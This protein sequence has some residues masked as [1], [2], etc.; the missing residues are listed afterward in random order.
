MKST[1]NLVGMVLW[2][3]VL[4]TLIWMTHDMRVRRLHLIVKEGR[5]FSWRNLT[6]STIELVVWLAFFGGMSYTTFF[7]NVNQLGNRI[8]Q[9]TRYDPL[10]LNTG[11]S[12]GSSYYVE[13]ENGEGQKPIQQYTYLTE[14]ERYKVDS[15]AATVSSGKDPINLPASAY[16]WNRQQVKKY[17]SRHQKAWV[18]VIET[19]YK[20]NF[21]NG[22]GLHAGRLANRFTLIR[23]P[24]HSFM[25]QK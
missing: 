17:D 20:K 7:Q 23:I 2:L 1:W 24:D 22:I 21:V 10:V 12:N 4:I 25:V 8:T 9:T 5:S 14:G 18:G 19:T 3:L 15:T 16:H 13:V 6:I 11:A